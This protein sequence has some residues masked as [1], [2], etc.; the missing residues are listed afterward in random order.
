MAPKCTLY[1]S[2]SILEYVTGLACNFWETRLITILSCYLKIFW[3]H[4]LKITINEYFLIIEA[5][6][7]K[8][9]HFYKEF[10]K[11]LN[12]NIYYSHEFTNK[13]NGLLFSIGGA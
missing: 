2:Y 11:L 3:N 9:L 8:T 7:E 6:K 1:V 4:K 5:Y 13:V 12:P 10:N